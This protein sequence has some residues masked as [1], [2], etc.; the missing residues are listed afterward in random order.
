[1]KERHMVTIL[2]A[3]LR[4][5]T[6]ELDGDAAVFQALAIARGGMGESELTDALEIVCWGRSLTPGGIR[7]DVK[8]AMCHAS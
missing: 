4:A 5:Q 1:M 6:P 2:T 7:C 8:E 3:L